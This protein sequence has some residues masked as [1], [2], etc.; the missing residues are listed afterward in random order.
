[1]ECVTCL[2]RTGQICLAV[3]VHL[4]TVTAYEA[5]TLDGVVQICG[6][7]LYSG[8][9][10]V[11]C[12]RFVAIYNTSGCAQITSPGDRGGDNDFFD[13][14]LQVNTGDAFVE[15]YAVTSDLIL[16]FEVVFFCDVLPCIFRVE[17][18][19]LQES[20]AFAGCFGMTVGQNGDGNILM[21]FN[22]VGGQLLLTV[23]CNGTHEVVVALQPKFLGGCI[24]TQINSEGSLSQ[25]LSVHSLQILFGNFGGIDHA[26]KD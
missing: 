23:V 14:T 20:A 8:E 12:V 22:G 6:A 25:L 5:Q 16:D 21:S 19:E 13:M 18:G 7:G 17:L 2:F 11:P 3:A 1:M 4:G 26:V 10:A 15:F 24:P 9:H